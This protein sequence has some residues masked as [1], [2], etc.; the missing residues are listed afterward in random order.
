MVVFFTGA[1]I[2]F[3]VNLLGNVLINAAMKESIDMSGDRARTA[4]EIPSSSSGDDPCDL[5][6]TIANTGTTAVTDFSRMDFIVQF[7]SGSNTPDKLTF[8][9]SGALNPGEWTVSSISGQ[10]EPGILN[11][12][13]TLTVE[14]KLDLAEAGFGVL[15]VGTPNGI[16]DTRPF[17]SSGT[18]TT[19]PC[20]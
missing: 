17:P 11:P 8:A 5:T 6:I 2:M 3:R 12:G 15:T 9:E 16:T 1:L 19:S 10:M 7:T 18:T 13:E 20:V 14:V 4:I